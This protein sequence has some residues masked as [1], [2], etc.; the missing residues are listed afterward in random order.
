MRG[1]TRV[2]ES[3]AHL[4]SFCTIWHTRDESWAVTVLKKPSMVQMSSIHHGH[5]VVVFS[6]TKTEVIEEL[7]GDG[8]QGSIVEVELLLDVFKDVRARV[9]AGPRNCG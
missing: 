7:F 8:M 1:P 3:K 2:E 6:E 5:G 4:P 9:L